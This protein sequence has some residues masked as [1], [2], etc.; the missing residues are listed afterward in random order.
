MIK[1]FRRIRQKLLQENRISK[2]LLYAIG[3]I[4]LVVIG[5]LIALQINNW[6]ERKNRVQLEKSL[7]KEIKENLQVDLGDLRFNIKYDSTNRAATTLVLQQLESKI[8]YIDSLATYYGKM[9]SNS[10]LLENTAAY[11]NLKTLG[12]DLISNKTL[13]N[14]ISHLYSARYEYVDEISQI[15]SSF[16]MSNLQPVLLQNTSTTTA[17]YFQRRP[18][19]YLQLSNN[20]HFM[21]ALRQ[22]LFFKKISIALNKRTEKEIL[23]LI[24]L[25]DKEIAP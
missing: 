12:F 13:R 9:G 21:E 5:I 1:F 22:D 10:L 14:K 4:V 20:A 17:D 25:I 11:E 6:N 18:N 19:N 15:Y 3:E 16:I 8:P 7:L 2:Y 24:A 23:E